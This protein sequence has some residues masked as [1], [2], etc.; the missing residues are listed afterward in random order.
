MT[1]AGRQIN[2]AVTV[3]GAG[4]IG[5]YIVRE[6]VARGV[7]VTSIDRNP[8]D[9]LNGTGATSVQADIEIGARVLLEQLADPELDAVFL[10][11][12]TG[13]VPRSLDH[14]HADLEN[15]VS[16]VLAVL[17]AV[18]TSGAKPPVI[19]HVS[20]A[21]VYGNAHRLPMSESHPTE[22]LSPYGVSKLAAEEYLRLYHRV[23][24]IPTLSMRPFSVFGPGQSK[25]VVHDLLVRLL[26]GE[27]PLLVKGSANVERDYVYVGDVAQAAYQLAAE[28][29]GEGESYN[30]STG[31]ATSLG[32]LVELL[33]TAS[34]S[35]ATVRF[36]EHVRKGDPVGLLGDP[37][38]ALALG[39]RCEADLKSGLD[40]TARWLTQS[41]ARPHGMR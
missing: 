41:T 13:F 9:R 11:V 18:R 12:G 32:D 14:P 25:L 6:L 23:Y 15:N 3:G 33:K 4:F 20:S 39:V 37:A 40:A 17:E 5:G 28:A 19:V 36:T 26:A 38:R 31:R 10:A 34:G 1:G 35:D 24:G 8:R 30:V 7:V 2:T 29:P 22:P 27:D 16:T 21:A